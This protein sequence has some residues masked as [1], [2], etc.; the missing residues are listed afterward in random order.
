[1]GQRFLFF[2]SL[3]CPFVLWYTMNEIVLGF[4]G[5]PGMKERIL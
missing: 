2:L 1:M 3:D 4:G 5:V